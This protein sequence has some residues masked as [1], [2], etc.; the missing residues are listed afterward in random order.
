MLTIKG[1]LD[2]ISR[3]W[4]GDVGLF[5]NIFCDKDFIRIPGEYTSV[6]IG[7]LDSDGLADAVL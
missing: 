5:M 4:R 3:A 1:M 7:T 6:C 2:V